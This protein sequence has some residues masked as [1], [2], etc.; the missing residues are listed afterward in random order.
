LAVFRRRGRSSF[1]NTKW[2]ITWTPW[3][4]VVSAQYKHTGHRTQNTRGKRHALVGEKG[5]GGGGGYPVNFI[6]L[7]SLLTSFHII[8][9]PT[10]TPCT[11]R[12]KRQLPLT[13]RQAGKRVRGEYAL[14]NNK[15]NLPSLAINSLAASTQDPISA[16]STLKKKTPCFPVSR[17]NSS[18]AF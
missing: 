11:P 10:I 18:I 2:P 9:T 5:R 12:H 17:F 15:S 4:C 14:L 3:L 13:K 6:A 1:V 16:K 8:H 7:S